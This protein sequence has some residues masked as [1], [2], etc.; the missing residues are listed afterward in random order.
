MSPMPKQPFDVPKTLRAIYV[1]EAV[2][3]LGRGSPE[4]VFKIVSQKLGADPQDANFRRTI[5]RDLKALADA[6]DLGVDFFTPDGVKLDA[7]Q[8]DEAKNLRAEYYMLSGEGLIQGGS[9]LEQA[10]GQLLLPDK[11]LV[12]WRA[13]DLANGSIPNAFSFVFE[14]GSG[15]HLSL[16]C[17]LDERPLKLLVA[18]NLPQERQTFPDSAL[19][20]GKFGPRSAMLF[21]LD[22][23]LSRSSPGGRVAHAMITLG[24]TVD[25]IE[26]EDFSS[27]GGTYYCQAEPSTIETLLA[28]ASSRE[29]IPGSHRPL[30]RDREW[31][32]VEGQQS[33]PLPAILKLG[34]FRCFVGTT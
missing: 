28:V 12:N 7:D 33:V 22:S 13:M 30:G 11:C 34:S 14:A 26:L 5:Y 9:L 17:K 15:H 6:G 32:P 27:S 18:R 1:W 23:S 29:T 4:S 31:K 19:L 8:L 2:K 20:G 24:Q 16:N 21:M 3:S 10:G 25:Q